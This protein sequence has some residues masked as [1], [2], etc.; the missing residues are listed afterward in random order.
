MII[1]I[2]FII[3]AALIVIVS[4]KLSKNAEL[5][6]ENSKLNAAVVGILIAFATSLPELATSLT[7]SVLGQGEMAISNILGS[8]LFNM[9]ILAIM[10]F[11]FINSFINQKV[12]QH[13]NKI[14]LF[15]ATIYMIL[16]TSLIYN[17]ASILSIGWM[18]VGSI[19]IAILYI[20]AIR[21]LQNDDE[22]VDVNVGEKDSAILKKASLYFGLLAVVILFTS[23][24]LATTANDIMLTFGLNASYVGAIFIGVST[25]LPELTSAFSLCKSKNYDM[26]ASSVLGSNLFNFLILFVVDLVTKNPLFAI[27]SQGLLSLVLLGLSFTILTLIAISFETKKKHINLIIPTTLVVLYLGLVIFGG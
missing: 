20:V 7:S 18:S 4:D 23:V 1:V 12:S 13:T 16:L 19:L 8:N 17:D 11:I 25:S 9:L 21:V 26:A 27:G 24:E 3:L 10:N 14:N 5:I 15:V 6:E 22:S 2:K